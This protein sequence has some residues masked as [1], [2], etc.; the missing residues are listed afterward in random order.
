MKALSYLKLLLAGSS[1]WVTT[2]TA[3]EQS[4]PNSTYYNPILPGW[5]SD[6]SC[7]HVNETFFCVTSTF[8]S[9]PGL[10]IYASADLI[11]WKLVSHVW[12]REAQIPG[13]SRNT[14]GQ[15]LGFY[16]ATL[17]YHDGFFYVACPY[18]GGTDHNLGLIFKTQDPF[19]QD[20]WND[21]VYFE[22]TVIDPDLFWD[23]DGTVYIAQSGVVLQSIDLETGA[24]SP[25]TPLNVWNGT[26]G[27]YPEGPHL[28]KKDG[29]YYLLIAE[30]GTEL[31]HSIT[32]SRSSSV[33]GPYESYEGNPLLTAR[34]TDSYF[35]TVGHGDLFQ[36]EAGNWW[37]VAL[38]TRCGPAYEIYPMGRE[39][40][41]YPVTWAEGEWPILDRIQGI[42]NGWPL[43]GSTRNVPGDGP[44]NSD[45]DTYDFLETGAAIPRNLVYWRVPRDGAFSVTDQGLQIIPSRANLTGSSDLNLTGQ[46]GLSFIG[47][48]QTD[49]LFTLSVDLAFNPESAGAE[50]GITVFLTQENHIDLGLALLQSDDSEE[51]P[52]LTLRLRA[53]APLVDN[54]PKASEPL[55]PVLVSVPST[56][57]SD[58]AI[59]LQ[60]QTANETHY[61]FSAWP[62]SN[63][64]ARIILGTASAQ[65]VS[66]GSGTFVGTLVGA[67]ATCNGAGEDLDCPEGGNAYVQ[68]WRYTGSAQAISAVELVS[69][70]I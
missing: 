32:I 60:V 14:T 5:H 20:S 43:P 56:W 64:N 53:E 66:G 15:Q 48:R 30:G 22:T 19:D 37:G 12:N 34:G 1:F 3:Q 13:A 62:S 61:R 6:P 46:E 10:P 17:R 57:A 41:L 27:A 35:Q 69:P 68:N 23:D 26:G 31:N 67:Y 45:P 44:F 65:L 24:L 63:P 50:A 16:A 36:D 18:L 11:D 7:I 59:T 38:S 4:S 52:Q 58:T 51:A 39:T 21:P 47:R 8:I 70:T 25:E 55:A 54:P 42:M 2:A 28:Y 49:T 40:V 9:F 29:W 33:W